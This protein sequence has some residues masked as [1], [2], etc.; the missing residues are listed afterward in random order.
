LKHRHSL[1]TRPWQLAYSTT[2]RIHLAYTS[3]VGPTT[4]STTTTTT[5]T[6]SHADA[7]EEP[8]ATEHFHCYLLRSQ[9]PKHPYKTY[10]GFTVN[11]H[12]RL[13]QHNGLLKHGGAWRTKKSGR[14]W[15]FTVIVHG[16]PSQ[17]LALQFEWAW[18][19]CD[20]SLAVRGA[21]GDEKARRSIKR[22]RAV[23]GQFW[24][25]KTLLLQCP[26]LYARNNLTLHFFDSSCK[27]IYEKI[28][29]DTTTGEDVPIPRI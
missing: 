6:T 10:V 20:R 9:D 15:E 3:F 29:V 1:E 26:E 21:I 17:K 5:T 7:T 19:H 14:P 4:T 22:K 28:P 11:P 13:R 8:E 24:I 23:R 18:Q 27:L 25:L 2:N 12:R 16:F